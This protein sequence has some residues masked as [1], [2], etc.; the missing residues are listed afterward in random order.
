MSILEEYLTAKRL[1]IKR[2]VIQRFTLFSEPVY[3]VSVDTILD[4][5][6]IRRTENNTDDSE[7]VR[8][9]S[10]LSEKQISK[11]EKSWYFT[12]YDIKRSEPYN[13]Y[14]EIDLPKN[15][16]KEIKNDANN[17]VNISI[18]INETSL[19]C[20]DR[21]NLISKLLSNFVW[22]T[23]LIYE[24]G[25]VKDVYSNID[26]L[27]ENENIKS[28]KELINELYNNNKKARYN[29]DTI[30]NLVNAS[31]EYVKDVISGRANYSLSKQER[32]NILERD[33]YMCQN[34]QSEDNLEV[35]HIIPISKGGKKEDENL[36]TL[37]F[38]CHFNIAHGEST[39]DIN[40]ESINEFWKMI[41]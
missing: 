32:E 27:L 14:K 21:S 13:L 7:F 37:C 33:D 19:E 25:I 30:S 11:F 17:R 36:C 8:K 31:E 38:E 1:R 24:Y 3:I 16:I 28:K 41:N 12:M 18:D 2:Q 23:L 26:N 10:Y 29:A 15:A 20:I 5:E 34:C 40:Y 35:H 39:A 6:Y 4:K 22:R 9:L